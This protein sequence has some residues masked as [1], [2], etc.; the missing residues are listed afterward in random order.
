L[1]LQG[2]LVGRTTVNNV[3]VGGVTGQSFNAQMFNPATSVING[4]GFPAFGTGPID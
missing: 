2:Q 1:N 3:L 4:D